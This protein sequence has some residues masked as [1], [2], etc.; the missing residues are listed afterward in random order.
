MTHI[1]RRATIIA[2]YEDEKPADLQRIILEMQR[3]VQQTCGDAF[4]P[5][6]LGDV[7]A[8]IIGLENVGT[9][10]SRNEFDK[11]RR[12]I[13]PNTD[14]VGLSG[15]LR[16]ALDDDPLTVQFGGFQDRDYPLT[17]RGARLFDRSFVVSGDKVVLIGWPVDESGLPTDLLA[18]LRRRATGFGARHRYHHSPDDGDPDVYMVIGELAEEASGRAEVV[19]M[20]RAAAARSTCRVTLS[21]QRIRVAIYENPRLPAASTSTRSLQDFLS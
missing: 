11:L 1:D 18:R 14:V 6:P 12:L 8:T 21:A 16:K 19:D 20:M 4:V 13:P 7:H 3:Q 17:S 9:L 10:T 5:R 15:F 2:L